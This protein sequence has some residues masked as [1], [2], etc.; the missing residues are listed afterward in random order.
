MRP[1]EVTEIEVKR[2]SGTNV[3]INFITQTT[4]QCI[5]VPRLYKRHW[6]N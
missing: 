1:L 4:K 6:I 3:T 2:M 5:M